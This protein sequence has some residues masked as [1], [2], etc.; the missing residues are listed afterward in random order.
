MRSINI[1]TMTSVFGLALAAIVP[2]AAQA[3]DTTTESAPRAESEIIVTAQRR[4]ERSV[5]VPIS[6]TAI[7]PETI[8]NANVEQ[9]GDIARVTPALRFDA[10]GSFFQPT[11][12]G[13]GTAITT[14][15]GGPNVGIYVDGFFQSNPEVADFT[16]MNVQ[17]IQV[18]KGPQGTLFGRNTT[19]GA[20]LVTTAEPTHDPYV[21]MKASYARYNAIKVQ[22]YSTF[23]LTDDIAMDIEGLFSNGDGFVTNIVTGNDKAGK[24]T[25]WSIRTGIKADISDRVSLL[26]RYVHS[27]TDDPTP[28]L[29]A[30]Y[31]DTRG[32]AG[33]FRQMS[34]AGRDVYQ[35]FFGVSDS[36]GLPLINL[37]LLPPVY[38]ASLPALISAGAFPPGYNGPSHTV[39]KNEI[40]SLHKISFTNNS[41]AVYGTLKI[42]TDFADITSYTQYRKDH[43]INHQD[44]DNSAANFFFAHLEIPNETF[45]QEFLFNSKPGGPLQWTAGLNYFQ[46]EDTYIFGFA[47]PPFTPYGGSGTMTKSYAAFADVTYEITPQL[48]L[49]GGARYS[50]DVVTDAYFNTTIGQTTFVDVNGNRVCLNPEGG[51]PAAVTCVPEFPG[52]RRI[53]VPKLKD[54]RVT[55]RVVLRYTPTD[56]SSVYASYTRGYK[57]GILNVGGASLQPVKPET[58]DAFEVGYKYDDRTLSVD[59]ASYYY[60]YNDLQVSSFQSGQAQIRNAAKSEIWGLEGSIRYRVAEGLSINAGAAYTHA[61]YKKF[62][63]APYYSYCDPTV[64]ALDPLYCANGPGGLAQTTIDASGFDMQRTPD[65]TG[66]IGAS[67]DTPLADGQLTLSGNLYYSSKFFLDPTQQF[68]QKAYEVLSLR[69]QW[70]D[71][72]DHFTIA[73]FG[74]NVTNSRYRTVISYNTIGTGVAWSSPTTYGIQV[75]VKY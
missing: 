12:R 45:S 47:G 10:A 60:F 5:D 55:P 41:D 3:Q 59:L 31:V 27:E 44:L 11:I 70:V 48:F 9:L 69:A 40:A 33:F 68:P 61:R 2:V 73:L 50:H 49:T 56:Q 14:S 20:I 4:E 57:A 62:P 51:D 13:V 64:G 67:Y 72:S 75:G 16:L 19:G 15:G 29:N 37:A 35:Q 71:P 30:S 52:Q 43:A 54:D 6:I 58:I 24:Y 63:N 38:P 66:N 25:N 1:H 26:V 22:G 39:K 53:D 23:G 46:N 8:S 74:D 28:L 18:L 7:S 34:Q 32:Q 36:T 65:F 21:E 17:S 42:D